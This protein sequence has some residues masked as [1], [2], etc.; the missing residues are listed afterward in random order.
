[1]YLILIFNSYDSQFKYSGKA[2]YNTYMQVKDYILLG[3]LH[4]KLWL[5]NV[6]R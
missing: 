5:I 2:I 4:Y 1:M 3:K 6:L